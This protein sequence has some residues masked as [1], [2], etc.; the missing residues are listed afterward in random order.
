MIE[1]SNTTIHDVLVV[2]RGPVRDAAL[3]LAHDSTLAAH[4]FVLDGDHVTRIEMHKDIP[5]EMWGSGTQSLWLLLSSIVH[6]NCEVSLHEV[7]SR[8]DSRNQAAVAD[9]VA[10]LCGV[11]R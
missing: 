11:T 6:R 10:A 5:F 3:I 4:V 1:S 9:A 7:V 8:L 2:D